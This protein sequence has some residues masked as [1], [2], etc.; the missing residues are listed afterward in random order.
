MTYDPKK[1]ASSKTGLSSVAAGPKDYMTGTFAYDQSNKF[2]QSAIER[3][4]RSFRKV[5]SKLNQSVAEKKD[6]GK[7]F[8]GSSNIFTQRYQEFSPRKSVKAQEAISL[9]PH[10]DNLKR[11]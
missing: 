2:S 5:D 10:K 9:S 11:R 8:E 1:S 3:R 4:S 6:D 7:I